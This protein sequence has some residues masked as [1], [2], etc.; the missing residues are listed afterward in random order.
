MTHLGF[1]EHP[2]DA[3]ARF[4]EQPHHDGSARYTPEPPQSVGAQFEVLLRVP[5]AAGVRRVVVRQV[6]DGEPVNVAA[7]LDRSDEAADWYRAT[8]TQS[9]PTMRY[10]FLTDGG[11]LGYQWVTAAGTTQHDPTDAAD[12]VSSIYRGGPDWLSE[13]VAYQIFPDRFARSGQVNHP[14][15]DWAVPLSWQDQPHGDGRE[16]SR[17]L[18]GGD[19][20]GII[21]HLDHIMALGANLL[22][23]TPVF[24]A[25]SNHRYNA[26]TF[27]RI[28]PLLGGD[29]GYQALIEAAHQRGLRI[30][31]DLTT[32]HTG[33]GHEWFASAQA[34]PKAPS[35]DYYYFKEHPDDYVG[36]LGHRGLPKLNYGSPDVLHHLVTGPRAPVRKY[37][38]EPFGLDG[39]RIDVANMTGRHG[40]DD[41]NRDVA[42]AVR[43]TV[44]QENPEAYLVGEHFHDFRPDLD[45][46]GWQ[47]VM[48]YA[49]FTKPLWS[50]LVRPDL[51]VDNW[52][53]IPW[54]GW[55]Q[56][57]AWSA[58]QSMRAYTAVPWQQLAASMS[59]ISSH[60]SPRIR[61]VVGSTDLVSVAVAAMFC[62]PG[63]PMI[64]SGDEV[65]LQGVTGE[66]GRRP[67]PWHRPDTWEL[68]TLGV[69]Q[70]F[71][72]LRHEHEALRNGSLR[73]IYADDD[74]MLFVREGTSETVLVSLNRADG[75]NFSVSPTAL[76]LHEGAE[77]ERLY[78][79]NLIRA[80]DGQVEIPGSGPAARLWRW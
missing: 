58:V 25:P 46:S 69:Y 73:W 40:A 4:G 35:A 47:G 67:F 6:H 71:S 48:N 70:A 59:I 12:F 49:G 41:F 62:Y 22:Y 60:D 9:G 17:Q 43:R 34:D 2:R 76:G 52:M 65:G 3:V 31:G 1:D 14:L 55:P 72:R 44:L 64:W 37:L 77:L 79:D 68:A 78:G 45:G 23:L 27:D 57:P 39:W 36:W 54:S 29:Q 42:Q 5:R 20:Y 80:T 11:S 8:L 19:F 50:W 26:D 10:R 74:R 21:A 28:D 16:I 51:P 24:P 18:C 13:A 15:P 30:I 61:T 75:P 7:Q 56:L 63:V 38:Q 33:V 53:G 66:E 32:N